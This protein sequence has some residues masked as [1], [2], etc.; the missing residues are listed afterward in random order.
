MWTE[1]Q[2]LQAVLQANKKMQNST[3]RDFNIPALLILQ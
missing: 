2:A 3:S 1:L